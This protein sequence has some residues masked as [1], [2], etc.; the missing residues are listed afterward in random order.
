MLLTFWGSCV[1]V[2]GFSI[3]SVKPRTSLWDMTRAGA[4]DAFTKAAK[5]ASN[6]RIFIVQLSFLRD[7]AI[8]VCYIL[9][10]WMRCA[11]WCDRYKDKYTYD[12]E[13]GNRKSKVN[14]QMGRRSMLMN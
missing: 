13:L 11:C 9:I 6:R 8:G 7:S 3:S 4:E 2:K 14:L 12:G 10:L 5:A 1:L